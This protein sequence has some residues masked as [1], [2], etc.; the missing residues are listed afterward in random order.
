MSNPNSHLI[1]AWIKDSHFSWSYKLKLFVRFKDKVN[2]GKLKIL[3]E[4]KVRFIFDA[5]HTS[6]A[7]NVDL[8]NFLDSNPDIQFPPYV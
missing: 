5:G 1:P 6:P 7:K 3:K 4:Q 2:L 8:K